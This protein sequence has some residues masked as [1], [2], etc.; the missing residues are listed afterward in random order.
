[1]RRIL[2]RPAWA[3]DLEV[4]S[5]WGNHQLRETPVRSFQNLVALIWTRRALRDSDGYRS[6]RRA[7]R[8]LTRNVA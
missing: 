6:A 8:R 5:A 2:G 3:C 1:M 7:L 4:V